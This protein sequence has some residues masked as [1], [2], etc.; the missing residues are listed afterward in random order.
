MFSKTDLIH[1]VP[2]VLIN[3]IFE[4]LDT[5]SLAAVRRVAK[6]WRNSSNTVWEERILSFRVDQY[7]RDFW[8]HLDSAIFKSD[9][10][11]SGV[12]NE[13]SFKVKKLKFIASLGCASILK[14]QKYIDK[15]DQFIKDCVRESGYDKYFKNLT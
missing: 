14:I 15:N 8:S 7:M 11:I 2:L 12:I 3:N 1:R 6:N 5:K 13:T 4:F 10:G 9:S